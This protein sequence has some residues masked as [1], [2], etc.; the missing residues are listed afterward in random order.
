MHPYDIE[1]LKFDDVVLLEMHVSRYRLKDDG[2]QS[3][4]AKQAKG[5]HAKT[6]QAWNNFKATFQLQ[7][8][9]LLF[10]APFLEEKVPE[11]KSTGVVI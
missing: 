10:A 11:E 8:I 9:S 4:P 2:T 6:V 5:T 3:S 7:S 1:D